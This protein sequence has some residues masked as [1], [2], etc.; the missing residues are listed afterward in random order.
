MCE[1]GLISTQIVQR[2]IVDTS[3]PLHARIQTYGVLPTAPYIIAT[4][5][6]VDVNLCVTMC[7]L[8]VHCPHHNSSSSIAEP[9]VRGGR[10][11]ADKQHVRVELCGQL[12]DNMYAANADTTYAWWEPVWW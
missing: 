2:F 10:A 9:D 4:L 7:F 11:L 5:A 12:V 6:N 1:Y 3:T 8:Q